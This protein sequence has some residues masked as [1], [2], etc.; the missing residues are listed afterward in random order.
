MGL[1]VAVLQ[2]KLSGTTVG[3]RRLMENIPQLQYMYVSTYAETYVC[4]CTYTL[5]TYE[6]DSYVWLVTCMEWITVTSWIQRRYTV[7]MIGRL[8]VAYIFR[9]WLH[10][11]SIRAVPHQTEGKD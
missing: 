10:A 11:G 7:V 2:I 4:S 3:G 6:R 5:W 1:G 8:K 9:D